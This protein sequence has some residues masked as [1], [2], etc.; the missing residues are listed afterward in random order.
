LN[1]FSS[2]VF[3]GSGRDDLIPVGGAVRRRK[4]LSK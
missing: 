1:S 3:N 4:Y 2:L